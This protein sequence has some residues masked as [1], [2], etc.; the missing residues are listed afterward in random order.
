MERMF[1]FVSYGLKD[2]LIFDFPESILVFWKFGL[3]YFWGGSTG[4]LKYYVFADRGG[5]ILLENKEQ[6]EQ[7]FL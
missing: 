6:K 3:A 5:V 1:F 2:T 4:T 7:D